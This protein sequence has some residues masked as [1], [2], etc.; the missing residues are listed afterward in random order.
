MRFIVA[1][2][3]TVS[4][5]KTTFLSGNCVASRFT[6]FSSVPIAHDE[7]DGAAS[8]MAMMYSVDPT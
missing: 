1:Q 7:P 5:K 6:R 8:S 2:K 4:S 3:H